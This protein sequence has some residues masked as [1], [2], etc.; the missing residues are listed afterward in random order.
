M[1]RNPLSSVV[2]VNSTLGSLDCAKAAVARASNNAYS[3]G[4]IRV[5]FTEHL[6][7]GIKKKDA[8]EDA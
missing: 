1:T 5:L 3:S 4:L 6:N 2:S 8:S 7:I